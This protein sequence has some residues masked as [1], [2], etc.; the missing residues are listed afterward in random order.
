[1][2]SPFHVALLRPQNYD[3]TWQEHGG[4]GGHISYPQ[5]LERV[6]KRF[7][8]DQQFIKYVL[9]HPAEFP[10]LPRYID[11]F[12]RLSANFG[13]TE[14]MF[15]ACFE[16]FLITGFSRSGGTYLQHECAAM[17]NFN[18]REEHIH[19]CHDYFP[20]DLFRAA[21]DYREMLTDLHTL[22][23]AFITF[24]RCHGRKSFFFRTVLGSLLVPYM[25]DIAPLAPG[26]QLRWLHI[27]RDI[28][29]VYKSL[30]KYFG[31]ENRSLDEFG[32][33]RNFGSSSWFDT[34]FGN[35]MIRWFMCNTTLLPSR[36]GLPFWDVRIDG[37]QPQGRII[38]DIRQAVDSY[39]AANRPN[40]DYYRL[41][42]PA[43]IK[44]GSTTAAQCGEAGER[45]GS[46]GSYRPSTFNFRPVPE[47]DDRYSR[48]YEA[49]IGELARL[50]QAFALEFDGRLERV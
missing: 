12:A 8:S 10:A 32:E 19:F 23:A 41:G 50:Y 44:F 37:G 39:L 18:I 46:G 14:K 3:Y 27:I 40:G 28:H 47:I 24:A 21:F 1:M 29:G 16:L 17:R 30:K 43:I 35:V 42:R 31:A 49:L 9:E 11:D 26:M 34:D 13:G 25:A 2:L 20:K 38:D 22:F 4:L 7:L 33:H 6:Q 45:C 15:D 5:R 48:V 36:R